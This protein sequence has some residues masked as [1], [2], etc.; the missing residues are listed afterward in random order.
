MG[1]H[2]YCY[3]TPYIADIAQALRG[4]QEQEFRAGRYDP[5]L[6]AANPSTYM[7]RQS[8]PPGP[9]F[10]SPGQQH[11]SIEAAR[12]ESFDGT[13]S[14]L[15][16]VGLSPWPQLAHASASTHESLVALFGVATPAH[17][18]V[19]QCLLRVS[20]NQLERAMAFWDEIGRGEARYFLVY[21]QHDPREIFFAGL[22][23]D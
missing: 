16:I 6:R 1:A 12:A 9:D 17:D 15:D 23:V 10:P 3:F 18:D 22:S 5:A 21:E 7:L 19:F 14:I 8:F 11:A 2:P 13:G 20:G 4:L